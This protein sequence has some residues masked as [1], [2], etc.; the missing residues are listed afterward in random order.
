MYNPKQLETM[1]IILNF[2]IGILAL[3]FF[4]ASCQNSPNNEQEITIGVQ[5][6]SFRTME[7][8]SPLAILEYIKQTGVTHVELMGN[9]AEPFAGAPVSPMS[10]PKVMQVLYKRYRNE[11]L[12]EEE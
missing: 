9:H 8:Q 1:K 10:D 2:F 3:P 12:T 4:I 6:W 5:T 7:D 11:S